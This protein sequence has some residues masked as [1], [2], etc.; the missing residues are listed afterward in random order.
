MVLEL[1]RLSDK[2]FEALEA[3]DL[4]VCLVFAKNNSSFLFIISLLYNILYTLSSDRYKMLKKGGEKMEK[5]LT[6]KK[7][8]VLAEVSQADMAKAVGI[9]R[10]TYMKLEKNPDT[11]TIAQAKA[12]SS[13]LDIPYDEIFFG[14][15]STLSRENDT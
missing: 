6:L 2:A 11:A 1:E 12:I 7:A 3:T 9:S 10:G 14:K 13:F 5:V 8:R 15:R 4:L